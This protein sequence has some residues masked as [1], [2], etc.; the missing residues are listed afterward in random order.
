MVITMIEGEDGIMLRF[1]FHK[2]VNAAILAFPEDCRYWDDKSECWIVD[3]SIW[4]RVRAILESM[5][6]VEIKLPKQ[7]AV[8]EA[9]RRIGSITNVP[10]K[11][12]IPSEEE[13]LRR[14]FS[15]YDPGEH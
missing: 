4:G 1:P 2:K 13:I 7:V 5:P 11:F 9:A 15:T 3:E 8:T 14:I 10:A 6:G 12:T